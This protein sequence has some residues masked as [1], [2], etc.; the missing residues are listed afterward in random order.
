LS[1]IAWTAREGV[2]SFSP[3]LGFAAM[4]P[5]S[6]LALWRLPRTPAGFAAATA[7]LYLVFVAFNKQALYNY[8][9]F[10]IGAL[11]CAVAAAQPAPRPREE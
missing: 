6:A 10:V 4:L 7:L 8:F 5:A 11:C 2:P 3:V 9:V 1:Y